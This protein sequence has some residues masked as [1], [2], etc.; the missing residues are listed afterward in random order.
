M[1]ILVVSCIDDNFGDNLIRICF[2]KLLRTA[3]KNLGVDLSS[4][5]LIKMSLKSAD[6]EL[7]GQSDLIFFAGGGLFGINYMHYYDYMEEITRMADECGVPVVLSSI[8]VNNMGATPENE[9]LLS[10]ML[11]RKCFYAVSVRENPDLFRRYA[12]NCAYEIIQ[13][14][15]PAVWSEYIYHSH[16]VKRSRPDGKTVVGINTV[17][18]GLFADN[19][20]PWKLGDEMKYMNDMK[21]LLEE[22]GTEYYFYTNGSFLDNNSLLYFAKEYEIPKERIIIPQSTRELVETIYG[23]SSVAAIRMH[24]SII[25]YALDVPSV[26]LVW[27]DKIPFFY[28]NIGYPDRAASFDEWSAE[29]ALNRLLEIQDDPGY[30]KDRKY[31]MSLYDFLYE[32]MGKFLGIEMNPEQKFDFD[33]VSKELMNDPVS[34]QE[35]ADELVLKVQK[36]EK[37]Y[38]SRFVEMKKKDKEFKQLK[39]DCEKKDK[40]IARLKKETEKINRLFVVRVYKK[41]CRI[42]KKIFK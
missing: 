19:G 17:R 40:E 15:D 16:L 5:E 3:L 18:G 13:V 7:I 30:K 10:E 11:E 31:M 33:R 32:L 4:V 36:G 42:K 20:K 35:D 38:L 26:N 29:Y 6:R 23:F 28:Q 21:M 2:E 34:L 9:H 39:K 27:N 12:K 37:H 14:C 25:S 22:R 24:S 41:L 8:G 1:K